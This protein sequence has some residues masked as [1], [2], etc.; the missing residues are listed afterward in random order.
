MWVVIAVVVIVWWYFAT[1][2]HY[3]KEIKAQSRHSRFVESRRAFTERVKPD[4]DLL[5][6]T[7]ERFRWLKGE[8]EKVVVEFMEGSGI[9]Q[10]DW[11]AFARSFNENAAKTVVLAQQGKID[12]PVSCYLAPIY[13]NIQPWLKIYA[14]TE[15]FLLRIEDELRKHGVNT[16]IVANYGKDVLESKYMPVRDHVSKYGH[17][18]EEHV[19]SGL[20]FVWEQCAYG[21]VIPVP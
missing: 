20:E 2:G 5:Y 12:I 8:K 10:N 4:S 9:H 15:M 3:I 17:A 19:H 7:T 6:K 11:E 16:R 1:M 13:A 21:D 14:M 18:K